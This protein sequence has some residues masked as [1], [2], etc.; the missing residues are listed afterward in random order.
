MMGM[1]RLSEYLAEPG[2]AET[3][4]PSPAGREGA[5]DF[6]PSCPLTF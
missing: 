5:I 2:S 6:L 1:R 4:A 3:Q